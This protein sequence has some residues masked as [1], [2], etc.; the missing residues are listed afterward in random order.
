MGLKDFLQKKKR[1]IDS[2][3]E[4]RTIKKEAAADRY[5][6]KLDINRKKEL[7]RLK[8]EAAYSKSKLGYEREVD[9]YKKYNT[10]NKPSSFN[11]SAI[12]SILG[13]GLYKPFG[14]VQDNTTQRKAKKRKSKSKKRKSRRKKRRK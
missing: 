12:N 2:F 1:Q 14:L 8:K 4:K 7:V 5:H 3:N 10:K 11:P 9:K 13:D 6:A